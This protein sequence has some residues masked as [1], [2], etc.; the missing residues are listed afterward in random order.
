MT[1]RF[2]FDKKRNNPMVFFIPKKNHAKTK[3]KG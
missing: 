2:L 3:I 1:Y